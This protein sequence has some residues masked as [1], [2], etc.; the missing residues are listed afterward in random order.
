M[1][2]RNA[3]RLGLAARADFR[4]GDWAEGID[5]RF[6][7]ILCNP[8]YVATAAELA[9]A[10]PS[11]S[12]TRPCSPGHDGLDAYRRLAPQSP[13]LLAPGGLA[14][15]RSAIDQAESAPALFATRRA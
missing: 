11:M 12:R 3:E 2:A 7:L 1:P 13:R 5:E 8:P 6:D 14:A 4:L 9:R 15:S 10:S